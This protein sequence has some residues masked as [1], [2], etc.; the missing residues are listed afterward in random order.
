VPGLNNATAWLPSAASTTDEMPTAFRDRMMIFRIVPE[1]SATRTFVL[2][3][4]PP[5][6][7][8]AAEPQPNCPDL[9]FAQENIRLRDN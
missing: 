3:G 5:G 8:S 1:S 9:Q 7:R 4:L 2:M 6:K